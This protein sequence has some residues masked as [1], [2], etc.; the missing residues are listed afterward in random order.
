M[1]TG[2]VAPAPEKSP[3]TSGPTTSSPPASDWTAT[4]GTVSERAQREAAAARRVPA[5]RLLNRLQNAE[6]ERVVPPSTPRRAC[7]HGMIVGPC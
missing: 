2:E 4:V 3:T 6:C 1:N 5:E 7:P